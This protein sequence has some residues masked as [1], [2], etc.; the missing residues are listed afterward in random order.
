MNAATSLAS[1]LIVGNTLLLGSLA[2]PARAETT[3]L[4]D[5][6]GFGDGGN[7]SGQPTLSGG[8]LYGTTSHS[9]FY[10]SQG[11]IFSVNTDGTDFNVIFD[12]TVA[13]NTI[14]PLS[15]TVS[16]TKLYGSAGGVLISMNTDGTDFRELFYGVG[17]FLT[18]SGSKLYATGYDFTSKKATVFS[19]NT[20]GTGYSLLHIF[21][22]GPDD[23]EAPAGLTLSG[24][25]LYGTTKK[26]G[27]NNGGTIFSINIDSTGY[28]LLHSFPS[29]PSNFFAG[30]YAPPT[31]F[32][33]KLYGTTVL[34]PDPDGVGT[35]FSIN[36]D[37][38]DYTVLHRFYTGP[39]ND[40]AYPAGPLT[41]SGSTLYGTTNRGGAGGLGTIFSLGLD[42]TGYQVLESFAGNTD[43]GIDG[44]EPYLGGPAIS[45]DGSTLFGMTQYGGAANRGVIFSKT[46]PE[47]GT[48]ALLGFGMFLLSARRR[49]I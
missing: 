36:T 22:G 31:V 38:T 3:I 18:L 7:P 17:D 40:G 13:V 4:H 19:I 41:L 12:F 15:L 47:P 1:L 42:G 27:S 45:P 2:T 44:D 33:S 35:I 9:D 5:F 10:T 16:G 28:S 14:A 8:K 29:A 24:S 11:T 20:D 30:P 25:T 39:D 6:T 43:D 34:N 32:G 46:I 26:G 37:G 21:Q 49:A 23:G 48:S